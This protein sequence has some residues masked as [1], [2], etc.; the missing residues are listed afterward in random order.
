MAIDAFVSILSQ[1]EGRE[2]QGDDIFLIHLLEVSILSQPEGRE[3]RND[4]QG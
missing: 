4:G 1:P 3:L 2:L